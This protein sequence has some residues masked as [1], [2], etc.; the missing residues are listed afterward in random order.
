M[1][2]S[3]HALVLAVVFVALVAGAAMAKTFKGK[4]KEIDTAGGKITVTKMMIMKKTFAAEGSMLQ[5]IATGDKVTVEYEKEGDTN[6]AS[7][8]EKQ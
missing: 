2:R 3:L 7:K 8:I 6:K 1:K 4:V 5:G